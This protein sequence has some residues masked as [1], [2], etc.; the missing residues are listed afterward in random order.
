MGVDAA[1]ALEPAGCRAIAAQIGDRDLF[2][3]TDDGEEDLTLAAD[4]DP[5]LT[6]DF[7]REFGE[8]AGELRRDD[9]LRR[10][11]SPV[12]TLQGLDLARL[13]PVGITVYLVNSAPAIA[14]IL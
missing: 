6:S 1:Q 5:Y 12:D 3:V 8:I 11:P 10:D 14:K 13:K 9:F 4:D 2:V 7:K